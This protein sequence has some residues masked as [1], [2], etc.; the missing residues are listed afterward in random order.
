MD[1]DVIGLGN[2]LQ[3]LTR[4]TGLTTAWASGF[5][6][7]RFGSRLGQSIGGGWLTAVA[8]VEGQAVFEFFNLAAQFPHLGFQ[9][10]QQIDQHGQA[11]A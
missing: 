5:L 11:R 4:V 7:Q 6:A 3:C 1:D 10:E 2:L 9:P 8:A